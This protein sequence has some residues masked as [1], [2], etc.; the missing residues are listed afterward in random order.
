MI[1]MYLSKIVTIWNAGFTFIAEEVLFIFTASISVRTIFIKLSIHTIKLS[2]VTNWRKWVICTFYYI[3]QVLFDTSP[4]CRIPKAKVMAKI[5][6][7]IKTETLRSCNRIICS[8]TYNWSCF[9]NLRS[10]I[11]IITN[12]N[13]F[14]CIL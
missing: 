12:V 6:V 5:K 13:N 8:W 1:S 9:L 14:I 10:T 4:N 2:L 11:N 7:E 3:M